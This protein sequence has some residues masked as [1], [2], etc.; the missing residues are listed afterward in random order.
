MLLIYVHQSLRN[1][2]LNFS[3][4]TCKMRYDHH[5][6][7]LVDVVS[8]CWLDSLDILIIVCLDGCLKSET[9]N[10]KVACT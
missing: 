7:D 6:T 5:L 4:L 2:C 1:V 10:S 9:W 8:V 3:E